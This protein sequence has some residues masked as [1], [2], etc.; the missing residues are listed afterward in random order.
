MRIAVMGTGYVGLVT[1]ACFADLGNQVICADVDDDKIRTLKEGGIPIF[2]PGLTEIVRMNAGMGRLEFTTDIAQAVK[3]SQIIFI[4]VGTPQGANGEADLIYVKSVAGTVGRTMDGY[5]LVVNKSTVPVGTGD[6]VDRIIRESQSGSYAFDLVSNPEFLREGSAVHDFMHPDRVVIG[7]SDQAAGR[8]V[9]ELYEPLGVPIII[10]D[11]LSAEM[12]KYTSNAFLALKISFIN[13]IAN[14]CDR[15]GADIREVV[16]GVGMDWRINPAFFGAGIGFGGSCF[17]KDTMALIDIAAKADYDFR[18][19]RAVVDV[20]MD[21][22]GHFVEVIARVLGELAGKK[23]AVWGLSF[24]P[25]T[26]DLRESPALKTVS[27]LKEKG[28]EVI[29][30][31]PVSAEGAKTL[32]KWLVT[33]DNPYDAAANAEALAVVTDWNMFKEVNLEKLKGLM[34]R[35]LIFDGRNIYEPEKVRAAGFEYY[36]VGRR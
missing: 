31:D 16:T 15:V 27:L 13:E 30:Y 10:T 18:I 24:K 35:P 14:V 2:E 34:K 4:A 33:T 26:D 25:N 36:G 5:R 23:I 32:M 8:M 17:P 3:E 11:V 19:M 28:A 6:I 9:A 21:Q 7:C 12:I 20:N 29:A 1:G 22:P